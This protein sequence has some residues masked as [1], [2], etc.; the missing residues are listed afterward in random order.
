MGATY[1][2]KGGSQ[3]SATS[4]TLV[5]S[6]YTLFAVLKPSS[7]ASSLMY[8]PIAL[9]VD[10]SEDGN[11]AYL[12]TDPPHRN[13]LHTE[14]LEVINFK[15]GE[16][17]LIHWTFDTPRTLEDHFVAAVDEAVQV[18]YTVQ[19]WDYPT[20]STEPQLWNFGNKT[21][22]DMSQ[23]FAV[24]DSTHGFSDSYGLW[25]A[26]EDKASFW[27]VGNFGGTDAEN[28][29]YFWR[30][31]EPLF[32]A[33][34]LVVS[35]YLYFNHFEKEPVGIPEPSAEP[36]QVLTEKPSLEMREIP[37]AEPTAEPSHQPTYAP[38]YKASLVP[39]AE[40]TEIPST[41]PAPVP[42]Q[43]VTVHMSS[44]SP[45]PEPTH[46][47]STAVQVAEPTLVPS[48][49]PVAE[50]TQEPSAAPVTEPTQEPSAA[51]VADPTHVSSAAPVVEPTQ[52]PS[53]APVAE[54][55]LVPSVVPSR[56]PTAAG[57]V[58]VPTVAPTPESTQEPSAASTIAPTPEVTAQ[59][60]TSSPVPEPTQ[61]PSAIFTAAPTT[62]PTSAVS[63]LN[64]VAEH[65]SVP[66][67][68]PT[69]SPTRATTVVDVSMWAEQ[70]CSCSMSL[71]IAISDRVCV[72]LFTDR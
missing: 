38:S 45:V 6:N 54:P 17:C 3:L 1:I 69:L 31:G 46:G 68:F 14:W 16:V 10:G 44:E 15:S 72:L 66:S 19:S 33:T 52:V 49:V 50:P 48:A 64:P 41:V 22:G 40:P 53:V 60:S 8:G 42:T 28:C 55:T 39:V 34:H 61:P 4:T 21:A 27:G 5:S 51:P 56:E 43:L 12:C 37:S 25:G 57:S 7:C 36:T 62:S 63:S 13:S 26:G 71:S 2:P 67:L 32:T 70:V 18:V 9:S 58:S 30:N 47:P 59:P 23:K 29:K 24:E 65:T 20:F 35:T 11:S